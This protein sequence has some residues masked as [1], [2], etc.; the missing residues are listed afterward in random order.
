MKVVYLL[1]VICCLNSCNSQE[2]EKRPVFKECI[3][4]I[5]GI[6]NSETL[7]ILYLSGYKNELE[8]NSIDICWELNDTVKVISNNN[9]YIN[10]VKSK[11]TT[12]LIKSVTEWHMTSNILDYL[13]LNNENEGNL[14]TFE[15]IIY[16]IKISKPLFKKYLISKEQDWSSLD[17]CQS[18]ELYYDLI[19]L[20]ILLPPKEKNQFIIDYYKVGNGTD[21]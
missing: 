20:I 1:F 11:L 19:K 10:K 13:F 16:Q 4:L 8:L 5:D 17:T 3:Q 21:W 15:E 18:I 9:D 6:D 7:K 2:K 14:I 12:E